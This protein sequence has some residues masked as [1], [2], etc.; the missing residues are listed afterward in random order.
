MSK[1]ESIHLY[2]NPSQRYISVDIPNTSPIEAKIYDLQG[3][4]IQKSFDPKID[5]KGFSK[6]IYIIAV[7][8]KSNNL[9]KIQKIILQ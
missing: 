6:G 8:D 3:R 2:P 4:L 9:I 5:L 7:T 1:K